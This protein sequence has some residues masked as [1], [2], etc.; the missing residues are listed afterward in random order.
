MLSSSE[1]IKL[2]NAYLLTSKAMIFLGFKG[3]DSLTGIKGEKGIV[4]FPGSRVSNLL[5]DWYMLHSDQ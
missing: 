4:G 3:L 5:V 2:L 1:N